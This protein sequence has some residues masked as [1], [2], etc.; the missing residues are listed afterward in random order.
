ML[1][2]FIFS[3]ILG[4]LTSFAYPLIGDRNLSGGE[5]LSTSV[6]GGLGNL[7]GMVLLLLLLSLMGGF[8]AILCFLPF[9]FVAPILVASIFA[10]YRR[11]YGQAQSPFQNTPPPP[12][13]FGN[14]PGYGNQQGF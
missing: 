2:Y 10:A 3:L 6:K 8:A 7:G 13:T 1:I 4:A 11:V 12:P 9:F 5:A 14:Q